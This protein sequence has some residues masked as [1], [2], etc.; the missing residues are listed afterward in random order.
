MLIPLPFHGQS[1]TERVEAVFAEPSVLAA[2]GKHLLGQNPG[3]YDENA[4]EECVAPQ[5]M[6][7]MALIGSITLVSRYPS[8]YRKA[9]TCR[10]TSP[11]LSRS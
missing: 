1:S 3:I 8:R 7:E 5:E 9:H 10:T 6:Q 11:L 2:T 4:F